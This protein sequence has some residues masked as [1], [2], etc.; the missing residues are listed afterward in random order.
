VLL[1]VLAYAPTEFYHCQHCEIVWQGVGFGQRIRAEQRRTALPPDLQ[2]EYAAISDWI[3]Q[4][5]QLYG[6][7]LQVKV[8]DVA[9][10]EGLIKAVC[11]R[12]RRFPAFI[13]DGRERMIGFDPLRL[14]AALAARLGPS[15]RKEVLD[16]TAP[17]DP[18]L[19]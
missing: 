16:T 14:D 3:A 10:I 15:V 17:R 11:H 12:A 13:V 4:T 9:S 2:A 7:R 18:K 1:E 5:L 6:P 8:V 19:A